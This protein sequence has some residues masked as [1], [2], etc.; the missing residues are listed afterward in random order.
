[1]DQI[2]TFEECD[3]C[4]DQWC[5][6]H[7]TSTYCPGGKVRPKCG[8]RGG[9]SKKLSDKHP[10]TGTDTAAGACKNNLIPRAKCEAYC[11]SLESCT[12]YWYYKNGRCCPKATF[13]PKKENPMCKILWNHCLELTWKCATRRVSIVMS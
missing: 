11:A 8:D 6:K 9:V 4:F 1:M 3:T 5:A 13:D 7:P 12:G 2:G 10:S